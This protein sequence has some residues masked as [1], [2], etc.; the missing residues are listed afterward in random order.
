LN[1]VKNGRV[2]RRKTRNKATRQKPTFKIFDAELRF[3]LID[4]PSH[5]HQNFIEEFIGHVP[6][7]GQ[8]SR[9]VKRK[10][11]KNCISPIEMPVKKKIPRQLRI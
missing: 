2:K 5:F 6:R 3:A 4:S 11:Y 8:V 7:S 9:K 10:I 1:F